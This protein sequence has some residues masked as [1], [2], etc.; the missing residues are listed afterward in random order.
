MRRHE[1]HEL[2]AAVEIW[3]GD[4]EGR[5]VSA[6]GTCVNISECGLMMKVPHAIP[7]LSQVAFRVARLEF[8][9]TGTV[10]HCGN[11]GAY[12]LVGVE[13]DYGQRY[14]PVSE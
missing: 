14:D 4:I 3:S 9:G 13:F 6:T 12:Y 10:R 5:K 8:E 1:R 11:T 2:D 7:V